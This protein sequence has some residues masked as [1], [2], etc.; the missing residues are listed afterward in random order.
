[1]KRHNPRHCKCPDCCKKR[2]EAKKDKKTTRWLQRVAAIHS[3]SIR[4]P[5]RA[6]YSGGH[7]GLKLVRDLTELPGDVY[8]EVMKVEQQTLTVLPSSAN[9]STKLKT[10]VERVYTV[11]K[12]RPEWEALPGVAELRWHGTAGAAITSIGHE[13]LRPSKDGLLGPGVYVGK[14]DKAINYVKEWEGPGA[15]VLTRCKFGNVVKTSNYE[16]DKKEGKLKGADTIHA[17]WGAFI[18]AWGGRIQHEE[19]CVRDACRVQPVLVVFIRRKM[20]A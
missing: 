13:F 2:T 12:Q 19:W 3:A 5:E 9:T 7:Q 16:E 20:T 11:V 1:M 10:E 14:L 4:P 17:G 6:I 15:L 8:A 18:G